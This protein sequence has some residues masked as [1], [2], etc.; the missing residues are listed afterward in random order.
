V[1]TFAGTDAA[2]C[3]DAGVASE[4]RV[5]A[6]NAQIAGRTRELRVITIIPLGSFCIEKSLEDFPRIQDA[7]RIH[8]LF[9][10][11]HERELF[12]AARVVQEFALQ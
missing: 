7:V 3:A 10:R 9:E 8:R 4:T 2:L 5:P 6:S 1:P 12:G 11:S